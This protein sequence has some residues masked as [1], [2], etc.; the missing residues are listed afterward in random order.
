MP[1]PA[2][3]VV[4]SGG[5]A[6]VAVYGT[7]TY[8]EEGTYSVTVTVT[9]PWNDSSTGSTSVNVTD[10]PLTGF[11]Q[12][13]NAVVGTSTGQVVIG[14]FVDA[15]PSAATAETPGEYTVQINWGDGT[16]TTSG[17]VQA[18]SDGSFSVL[19]SHT[20]TTANTFNISGTVT[21]PGGKTATINSSAVAT[22]PWNTVGP[23]G[24]QTED[25]LQSV[26]PPT[27]GKGGIDTNKGAVQISQSLSF[28]QSCGCC[29]GDP[30]LDYNGSDV[31]AQPVVQV[32]IQAATSGTLPSSASFVLTWNGIQQAAVNFN[33]AGMLAGSIDT[34]AVQV[35][36]AVQATGM[37]AWSAA[38]TLTGSGFTTTVVNA[39]GATPVVVEDNSPLGAGWSIDGVDKV[40]SVA[41]GGGVPAGAML[42]DG[43]GKARFFPSNGSGGYNNPPGDFGTLTQTGGNFT[44]TMPDQ[45][46][47]NFNSQGLQSS[48]VDSDGVTRTYGYNAQNS[49]TTVN[50]SDGG[51]STLVYD[52][53]THLLTTINEPGSR[54]LSFHEDANGNLTQITDADGNNRTLTYDSHHRLTGDQYAPYNATYTYDPTSGLLTQVNEGLGSTYAVVSAAS[55]GLGTYFAGTNLSATLTDALGHTTTDVLDSSG[56][57]L[58]ESLADGSTSSF[59][60]DANGQVTQAVDPLH[61]PT[62]YT[63]HYGAYDNT[64]KAGNG[65][66]MQVT[67]ADG[68]FDAFQYE[69]TF[70]EVT[71]TKNALGE[72]ETNTYDPATGDLLT[73]TD[74]MGNTTTN[75]WSNGLLVKVV[76]PAGTSTTTYDSARRPKVTYD[77]TGAPTFYSYDVTGALSSTTDALGHVTKT[78]FN[79]RR[80]LVKT[81]DPS[82]GVTTETYTAAGFLSGETNPR[83]FTMSIGYDQRGLITSTTDFAG[84]STNNQFDVA[85]RLTQT[86]DARGS[87]TQLGYDV[88]NRVTSVTDALGHVS[89]TTYDA[90]SEVIGTTDAL[91]R[92]TSSKYDVLGGLLSTTDA[93]GRTTY[94]VYDL[95]GNEIRTIDGR[96]IATKTFYDADNRPVRTVDG[97][98]NGNS[99]QYDQ[100]GRI[101]A[102]VDGLGHATTFT[103]DA[104]GRVLTTTDPTGA[105]SSN[106]YDAFGNLVQSVD[107]RGDASNYFYD[108]SNRQVGVLD[109]N[110]NLSRTLLDAAGNPVETIDPNGNKAYSSFDADNR[111][112]SHTDGDGFVSSLKY[113]ANGNVVQ[114]VDRN[115]QITKTWYDAVNRAIV[116]M[117]PNGHLSQTVY[118]PVGDVVATMDGNGNDTQYAFDADH[119]EIGSRDAD[120]NITQ[121]QFDANGAA[122]AVIDPVGNT[123]SYVRD[124]NE[125]TVVMVEPLNNPTLAAYDQ[126]DR[127]V[128]VTDRNGR[129]ITYAYDNDGRVLTETW[130]NA[131]ATTADTLQYS[132]DA[133]GNLLTAS[134]GFGAYS[135]SYDDAGRLVSQTD[136][137]GLT[138]TY[139]YDHNDNMTSVADSPGGVL[140]S[141]YDADNR[142]TSRRFSGTGQT[143]LRLDLTYT[144]EGQ[145]ATETRY[146]DLAGQQK[147]GSSVITYDKAGNVT[148]IVHNNAGG[149]P[150]ATYLSAHDRG[151]RLVTET[152][153]GNVTNYG[154][155]VANQ[156]TSS[157]STTFTYDANGN[158]NMPGY[159]T[160]GDNRMQSD[161][162]WNYTYD[163]EGNITVKTNITTNETWT[164]S[165]DNANRLTSAVHKDGGGNLIVQATEKYDVFGN[166]VEED[167]FTQSTGQTVVSRFAFS[168]SNIW[169]D[170]NGSNQLQMRRLYLDGLDQPYARISAAGVVTWYLTDHLGSIR[171]LQ[172]NQSGN[173]V[174][175]VDYDAWGSVA[176]ET[177]ASNGDGRKFGGYWFDSPVGLYQVGARWYSPATGRWMSEDPL[178]LAPDSNRNRYAGNSPSNVTDPSGLNWLDE[179]GGAVSSFF[180][181]VGSHLGSVAQSIAI[182]PGPQL[183]PK[184][185]KHNGDWGA[186]TRENWQEFGQDVSN[187]LKTVKEELDDATSDISGWGENKVAIVVQ[188]AEAFGQAMHDNPGKT[189]GKTMAAGVIIV[190]DRKVFEALSVDSGGGPQGSMGG[191]ESDVER[192]LGVTCKKKGLTI[193]LSWGGPRVVQANPRLLDRLAA[194]RAYRDNG[195]ALDLAPWLK[196]T[197]G[198]RRYGTGFKSGFRKWS[199]SVRS[200]HGNSKLSP[201]TAYLYRLVDAKGNFLKWG[202]TQD[203]QKRYPRWYMTDKQILEVA[204][205]SRFDMLQLERY[206][207]QLAPGP[208]NVR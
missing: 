71:Q 61:R 11:G 106:S 157:G 155:D 44:Y 43:S 150:I 180:G 143:P 110:N 161:G 159:S 184:L 66:L 38:V 17:T 168:G 128:S 191:Y 81:T 34:L 166:R 140:T 49:L 152:D 147:V 172:D 187:T 86:T 118:S 120:G 119:E 95:A 85:E 194:F 196:Q 208:W 117:D 92:S 87:A 129:K 181:T 52:P 31:N 182:V 41:G 19:G 25:P 179:V 16:G 204:N 42:V 198:N 70:H 170:L 89:G 167:V 26:P 33:L 54:H 197:Q 113:D 68:S 3:P 36:N 133:A 62:I 75:T 107:E 142:L 173:I 93:M 90:A 59:L 80:M 7:A 199:K 40:V 10:A 183:V 203:L 130:Y 1:A 91:G 192:T 165:W 185:I 63:Y 98:G 77:N 137:F 97:N 138:L 127:L 132:Y 115:G 58:A 131:D 116:T 64:L 69:S 111:M 24:P 189:L 121:Q 141:L 84:N 46:V 88:D 109:P 136:P 48:V 79:N 153:N 73:H 164:Y 188:N 207:I 139:G 9:D 163:N 156:L 112:T 72:I 162:T 22:L 30:A 65:D 4:T 193:P 45:T 39:S 122:T 2:T 76:T 60:R 123:T 206:L 6:Q 20:Y 74:A 200:T 57:L 186:M 144:G 135:F 175:H 149:T 47:V 101:V 160:G 134:N 50:A 104:D 176:N 78:A 177:Q 108:V 27:L 35:A 169:A 28:D 15:N 205:G 171:D 202:V 23:P 100:A 146:K 178:G 12:S 21:D 29:G 82:Q 5:F 174:D 51:L 13:I 32:P 105:A 195:G 83:G 114:S 37:Y 103:L 14:G 56:R 55:R 53:T 148:S 154:Y 96:G 158:R 201:R 102:T 67:Y 124:A 94:S 126:N 190:I 8:A 99:V 151:D 125:N 145:I 18:Q